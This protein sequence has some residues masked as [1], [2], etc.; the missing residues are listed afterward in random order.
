[1]SGLV[2][3][4]GALIGFD[5]NKRPM[6]LLVMAALASKVP[7]LV[8]AGVLGQVWRDGRQ[9]ARLA[10]LLKSTGVQ[11]EP[12][13]DQLAREAGQL[14]GVAGTADVIDASVV[15]CARRHDAK[16]VTSDGQDLRRLD[17]SLGL[18]EI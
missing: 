13:A 6:V 5:R 9:Q 8:P 11:I 4:A 10:K 14:C 7:M 18:V 17:R 2:L 12:L 3:D 1:M 16:V 15:L